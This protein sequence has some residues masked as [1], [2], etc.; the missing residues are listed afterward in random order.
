MIKKISENIWKVPCDSNV[1]FLDLEKKIIIDTGKRA[2]RQDLKFF[3]SKVVDFEKVEIV[4]LTHL[5]YDHI[6]NIDLFP[7]AKIYTSKEEISDY[8][9]NPFGA[10]LN[11]SDL[12]LIKKFE[13]IPIP[14]MFFGLQVLNT[15]GHTAGSIC[16]FDNYRKILFSG[17]T[18]FDKGVF[19]RTDL[20]TS[21]PDKMMNSIIRLGKFN[22]NILCP[23][24]DY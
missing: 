23:G 7:N 11:E 9:N 5:H 18:I 20:P 6:G 14:P 17:D 2:N 22:Y 21:V 24:H 4:I 12:E 3:L 1:Y 8:Q 19:G 10:V 16:L 15:P 13:L